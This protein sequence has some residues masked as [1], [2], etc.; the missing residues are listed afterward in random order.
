MEE[1][2]KISAID[3]RHYYQLGMVVDNDYDF[4]DVGVVT[5]GSKDSD[6]N[7]LSDHEET[8]NKNSLDNLSECGSEDVDKFPD[9]VVMKE[10]TLDNYGDQPVYNLA[11]ELKLHDFYNVRI[12]NHNYVTKGGSIFPNSP[13]IHIS[14]LIFIILSEI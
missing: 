8:S 4:N 7:N 9:D 14:F 1:K 6:N 3:C 5:T 12:N 2:L 11:E 10:T 13:E